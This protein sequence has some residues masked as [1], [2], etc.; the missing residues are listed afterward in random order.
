MLY[1]FRNRT[2]K[3]T[4]VSTNS[5]CRVHSSAGGCSL[6]ISTMWPLLA[7]NYFGARFM[8]L[9]FSYARTLPLDTTTWYHWHFGR[10][11][12][13]SLNKIT[14]P[15]WLTKPSAINSPSDG[16]EGLCCENFGV[17]ILPNIRGIVRTSVMPVGRT[18]WFNLLNFHV[19]G[20]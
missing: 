14:H 4:R 13:N 8:A 9:L 6:K 16:G 2:H 12:V 10:R 20:D 15:R 11:R 1:L 3:Y 19:H 18:L 17:R 5:G 7:R